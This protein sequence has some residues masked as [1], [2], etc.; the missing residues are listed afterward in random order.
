MQYFALEKESLLV[1]SDAV[2]GNLY[3]CPECSSVLRVRSG[4]HRQPHFY[5]VRRPLSCRQHEKSLTHL[6]VQKVICEKLPPNEGWLEHSFSAIKRI[7]DVAWL[8]KNIIFEIQC[9]PISLEEVQGRC[10]DYESLGIVPIWILHDQRYNQ[11]KLTAAEHYLRTRLCFFTNIDENGEGEFY[12][13]EEYTQNYRRIFKGR[14]IPIDIRD[15]KCVPKRIMHSQKS[16]FSFSR[17]YGTLLHML[18]ESV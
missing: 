3:S 5:H 18:L 8:P 6:Q 17:F 16:K 9:S 2:K 15:P 10:Q 13:Q 12:D 11:K 1:A 4:P 14:K 7:A